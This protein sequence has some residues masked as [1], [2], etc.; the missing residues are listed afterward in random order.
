MRADDAGL[1]RLSTR[2]S[3]DLFAVPADVLAVGLAAPARGERDPQPRAGV[4]DVTAHYGV[5][6]PA[7]CSQESFTGAA[8]QVLGLPVAALHGG[9]QAARAA[10]ATPATVST[11]PTD[12]TPATDAPAAT[13]STG[14]GGRPS[15][16]LLVGLGDESA[17]AFR[18]VG[19]ALGRASRGVTSLATPVVADV[20]PSC[21]RAFAEGLLLASYSP[22]RHG[23]TEGPKPPVQQVEL[24]GCED[25]DALRNARTAALATW[26]VR[27]LAS[28][29]SSTKGPAWVADQAMR[30]ATGVPGVSIEV[31]D[32]EALRDQGFGGLLGV[33][34]GSATPPC[35]VRVQWRP[36]S[37]VRGA[38]SS[39]S[40]GSHVVLVGTGITFD[41]GGLSIKPREAM[42]P[43]K[44]DMAGA[45]VVL[46]TVLAAADRQLPHPVT[47]L[48][49]LAENAF[50]A[51][52]YR[53]GDVLTVYGGTTVEIV[54]T[55]AEGRL[56]LADALAYA[57]ARLDPDVLVDVATLTG[58]ASLGLGRRHAALY[59]ADGDLAAGLEA[60]AERTGERV[61]RM[62]LVEDYRPALDS[63]V[64][65]LC[66]VTD[67]AVSAGSITA[68]LFLREFVG[69]RRWAHLDIAGPARADSDEHEVTKGA[70]GYGARLLL[71]WLT[72]LSG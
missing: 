57:D 53:P 49:P 60:A 50:G 30:L 63:D 18:R 36:T 2:D 47:A 51:S 21:V 22:P 52:S 19:A 24:L 48:L 34:A 56:V 62:P 10:D 7:V 35:L 27:D 58:A 32:V 38:A 67:R 28:T 6:L 55:D 72:Q 11:P 41:T 61:W 42:V 46:A 23:V 44:T 20:G 9:V 65:D 3:R 14:T 26:R 33:G 66:H 64:A 8:G 71:D 54:N 59:T 70:T 43:M 4:A 45:G 31:L 39:H 16:L 37:R 69:D 17:V 1:P 15:R 12:T 68:A 13:G 40:T 5:D 25:D 29:P